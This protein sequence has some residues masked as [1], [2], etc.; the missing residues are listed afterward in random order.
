MGK[1]NIYGIKYE[2]D[3]ESLKTSTKEAGNQ[4]K[5]A[6]AQFS[7]ATSKMDNWATSVD[8]VSAKI[9]QL[10][11][12]L[13]AEKSKL[14]QSQK[15]YNDTIDTINKYSKNIDELKAKKQQAIEQYGA[16]SKEVKSLSKEIAKLEREQYNTIAT[17]NNLKV[18]ITNQQA[19]VNKT[20]KSL[21]G[22]ETQLE[23][24]KKAQQ[25]A[26]K[27]GDSL[28]DELKKIKNSSNETEGSLQKLKGGFTVVK[29]AIAGLIAN[30]ITNFIS[31]VGN[32]IQETKEYRMELGKLEATAQTTGASFDNVKANLKEVNSITGDTGAGVE[33]LNNLMSAGF[34][35]KVLDDIT[36]QLL[37][38]SIKWKDTLK[39]EGL[40]DGLQ[41]TL[42]TG[43][44]VGPFAELLE[45][46]GGNLDDFD[47]GLQNAIKSGN[48]QNYVLD[49]L[50]KYGLANVKKAYEENN[51]SLIDSAN[52]TFDYNDK[53]AQMSASVE[54]IITSIKVGLMDLTSAFIGGVNG[55][56]GEAIAQNIKNGFQY[57]IDVVVPK[58][59]E[60]FN[61]I[62]DHAP[63]IISALAGI[64]AGF[65]AFKIGGL[66]TTLVGGFKTLFTTLKAGDGIMKAL[67]LTMK[68]NPFIL[69]ATLVAGLVVAF[70]TLW[71][72]S[73]EFRNFFINMWN[74]IKETVSN[75][76]NSLVNFFTVT[77]PEAWNSFIT[78]LGTFVNNV[79]TFFSN[80]WNN[81]INFFTS[82]IPA[83]ID[84]VIAFFEKIPYYLGYMVGT[85][86]GH[87]LKWGLDLWNF[88]TVTIPNFINEV[89]KWFS[90]L[91][92]KIWEWL[93]NTFNKVVAFG[94]NMF[95]KATEIGSKF[96]NTLINFYAQLPSKIWNFLTQ[97]FSKAVAFGSNMISK[98]TEIGSKFI[99]NTIN[100]ISQLPSKM[101]NYF[102]QGVSKVVSFGSNLASKGLEAGR[103]LF[104]SIVNT[105][106]EIPSEMLNIGKNIVEGLWNGINNM[107]GW[108]GKKVKG[109]AKGILDGIKG[110][111]DT[112]SP[113][114][115]TYWIG[116]MLD[117]G[118]GNAIEDGTRKVVKKAKQMASSVLDTLKDKFKD[119]V[120]ID[121]DLI[122][123]L[124]EQSRNAIAGL[125]SVRSNQLALAGANTNQ[126][127]NVTFNQNITSPK[128]LDSL[129]IYRNT[130][131]QIR[132][133]KAWTGGKK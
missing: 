44:A 108:I 34:D 93:V 24:V 97:T 103:N 89:I 32:A 6:N 131:K 37:G 74:S 58:I 73:D 35:G 19:S 132:Q 25:N 10:N 120:T 86:I 62:V 48:E 91:P 94:T 100:F 60:G 105:V 56:D 113:S 130:Q 15:Q 109:F 80:M 76:V 101:W 9:T 119:G 30:G 71:N 55:I 26:E 64:G 29:G 116:E 3:I 123:N 16:E 66:I 126:V 4:I 23:D 78:Y 50:S 11:A 81:I 75:V 84:S 129:E 12:V 51:K 63:L 98:A 20:E 45:R 61:F 36:D 49:Y 7:E 112:H 14:A 96:I 31:S 70:I 17:A 118:L 65:I 88:A 115:E 102:T 67:N 79:T 72:T 95:N 87:F 38:A 39:F 90:T 52:A 127:N 69:V 1:E 124:K 85:V 122:T 121:T 77:V 13:Q 28:E 92:S 43:N 22:Y 21:K 83:W 59:K 99:T 110:V 114:R 18:S 111:F 125:R 40:S 68:A 133:L 107:V 53:M 128:P 117:L 46:A 33:G 54:P 27:S 2:V 42:A 47:K 5:L 8:G 104:N 41:E 106:S 57:F 82:T